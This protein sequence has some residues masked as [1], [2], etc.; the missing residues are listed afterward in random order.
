MVAFNPRTEPLEADLS[1]ADVAVLHE[2]CSGKLVIEF[3][4]GGST[5][6]LRRFAAGVI[7]YETDPRW[8]AV[9]KK[10]VPGADVRRCSV[11]APV[12]SACDV[13]FIDGLRDSRHLWMHFAVAHR[14]AP[15]ILAHDTRRPK[16]VSQ[17]RVLLEWP[18]TAWI[19][20]VHYHYRDSNILVVKL[21]SKPVK[22]ENWNVTEPKGR[23]PRWK[24]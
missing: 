4:A 7:T 9:T 23:L 1:R 14:V 16:P 3:G 11:G 12:I 10:K 15:I 24:V 6:L 19:D 2:F 22:Y 20:S 17:F 21:R 5:K 8:A 18:H 13:L